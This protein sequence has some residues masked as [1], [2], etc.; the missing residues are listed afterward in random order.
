MHIVMMDEPT[1]STP[2]RLPRHALDEAAGWIARLGAGA[3]TAE[4]RAAF[5]AWQAADPANAEAYRKV[6]ALWDSGELVA[7]ARGSAA[8][9]PAMPRR[10]RSR[11]LGLVAALVLLVVAIGLWQ[12][13]EVAVTLAADHRTATGE[14]VSL[15]LSDG[16]RMVLN[17]GSAV[18]VAYEDGRRQVHLLAG[19]AYFEVLRDPHRPFEVT[20]GEASVEVLGTAFAVSKGDGSETITVRHGEVAVTGSGAPEQPAALTAGEQVRVFDGMTGATMTVDP[21]MALAWLDGRLVFRDRPLGEVVSDLNR[22]HSGWI[23]I[24]DESLRR[25]AV[26]GNYRLDDPLAAAEALAAATSADLTRVT[27]FL[28][29]LH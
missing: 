9:A 11:V 15:D 17:S 3:L 29:V 12:I 24:L 6:A 20:S 28:T 21:D 8:P 27:A 26:S 2:D 13:E 10:H 16:S 18:D 4:E 19:E 1:K 25:H 23:V 5:E 14:Q 7:A 22:Y